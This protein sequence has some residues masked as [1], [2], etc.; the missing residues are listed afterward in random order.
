MGQLFTF[1]SY[2]GGV[3]RSMAVANVGALMALSGHKVLLVDWDIEAPG[4]EE[5]FRNTGKCDIPPDQQDRP[6]IVDLLYARM[7]NKLLDWREC[8]TPIAL[9]GSSIS[10]LSAGRRDDHYL[11]KLHSLAWPTLF[12]EH[13]IGHYFDQLRIEWKEQYDFILLDSRTGVTDIGDICTAI[14]PDVLVLMFTSS[15]QSIIGAKMMAERARLVRQHLPVD[16]SKL[17]VVPVCGRDETN[18][19]YYA[20]LHWREIYK[21]TLGHFIEEWLPRE[22]EASTV[23]NKIFIPYVTIWA[24][25]ERLP[26]L[27]NPQELDHPASISA[28]YLR[29][30]NLLIKRLDWRAVTRERE[31]DDDQILGTK[32]AVK[33]LQK[34]KAVLINLLEQ[35][36]HW[37]LKAAA[38]AAI[39]MGFAVALTEFGIWNGIWCF[40]ILH[41][42]GDRPLYCVFGG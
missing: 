29:L 10:L 30:A 35:S 5:F 21:T 28:A 39:G 38:I 31:W 26:V 8:I 25:G 22:E 12:S 9:L 40:S 16:R 6:G 7:D 3:G 27:E 20:S 14:M 4:L 32:L 1:F 17:L 37:T 11:K 23:I 15:R 41:L 18:N 24:L 13:D 42:Y 2:K 34:D 19:E 33:E 36:R